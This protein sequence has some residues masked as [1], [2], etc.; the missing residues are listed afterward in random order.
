M[1]DYTGI[2]E[3]GARFFG[4]LPKIVKDRIL[5]KKLFLL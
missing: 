5:D 3:F 1:Y 2:E 4:D